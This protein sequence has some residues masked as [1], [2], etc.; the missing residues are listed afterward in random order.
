M[1]PQPALLP[2]QVRRTGR[3]PAKTL[4][5]KHEGRRKQEEEEKISRKI[6][7][8]RAFVVVWKTFCREKDELN[9]GRTQYVVL[10]WHPQNDMNFKKIGEGL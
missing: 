9:D 7:C 5:R 1:L 10:I 8:L 4:P 6:S 3:N 2:G